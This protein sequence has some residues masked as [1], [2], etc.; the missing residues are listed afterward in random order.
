VSEMRDWV[1]YLDK[2]LAQEIVNRTM[3]IIN[4]NINVMNEK[5]VIIA[6]GDE[7]RVDTIHEGA[8]KVIET[9]VGFEI[10][11]AQ[12]GQFHGV[13]AG[14]N[15]PITFH[16]KVVGVIGITGAPLEIRNYGELVKMAAEMILQQAFLIEEM[17]WDE[18]LKEEL[19][20]KLLDG[21]ES[22][23]S[24][25]LDRSKRLGM[26]LTIPRTVIIIA[27]DDTAK[28]LKALRLKLSK[29][30]LCVIKNQYVILLKRVELKNGV[31]NQ[32]ATISE[33]ERWA[34]HLE[35]YEGLAVKFF[36]GTYHSGLKGISIAYQEAVH[37]LKVGK[38]LYP[39]KTIY[40]AEDSK[41]PIFLSQAKELGLAV[42]FGTYIDRLKQSDKKGEL[43]ETLL[44]YVEEDGDGNKVA[45]RLFIHR[46]TLRYRL[47]R[48]SEL[49][50]KDPR[51]LKD[52]V[53][54]YLSVLQDRLS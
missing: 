54:L 42:K 22:F 2:E 46:N 25:Y 15:L 16:D 36:L 32:F 1:K 53:E 17:Q 31:W 33:L 24:L 6:S 23:D 12:A 7:A 10:G 4:W 28:L 26:D 38:K 35:Y 14:I 43:L 19:V 13:K 50:G 8:L 29:D 21:M 37:S 30:D 49:T 40:F 41:L 51:K 34:T 9:Q 11:T 45:E 27:A 52:L 18:R 48:I 5:G 20:T 44:M 3:T 39:D 47:E